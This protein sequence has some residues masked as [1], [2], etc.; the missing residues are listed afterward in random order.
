M[1]SRSCPETPPPPKPI[2][3]LPSSLVH[4][5]LYRPLILSVSTSAEYR[6][7]FKN[8]NVYDDGDPPLPA[9]R[10][11]GG[12]EDSSAD[13]NFFSPSC[14][15]SP[16]NK[17]R[18]CVGRIQKEDSFA[19]CD[20]SPEQPNARSGLGTN[21]PFDRSPI[22]TSWTRQSPSWLLSLM[23]TRTMVL[24]FQCDDDQFPLIIHSWTPSQLTP[25]TTAKE[26]R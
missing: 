23:M 18:V 2:F 17:S 7:Y 10:L 21:A 3:F 15:Y 14:S 6:C 9:Q 5:N 20:P 22:L 16:L 19:C 13:P 8:R 12:P 25:K 1:G 11:M 24:P 26:G 4:Y